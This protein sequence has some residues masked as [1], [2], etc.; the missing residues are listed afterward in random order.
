MFDIMAWLSRGGHV[1]GGGAL[2][3]VWVLTRG[4]TVYKNEYKKTQKVLLKLITFRTII[5]DLLT[6]PVQ[7]AIYF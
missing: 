5:V 4:N 7:K 1:L 2:I 3:S 6:Y